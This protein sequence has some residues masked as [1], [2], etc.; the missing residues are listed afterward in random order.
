MVKGQLRHVTVPGH[1]NSTVKTGT[2][3]SIIRQSALGEKV[4]RN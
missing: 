4:F 3:K 2:L 1:D